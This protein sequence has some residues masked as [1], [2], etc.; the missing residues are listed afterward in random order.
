MCFPCT[1]LSHPV[2]PQFP[3]PPAESPEPP[4]EPQEPPAESPEPPAESPTEL[5]GKSPADITQSS[6]HE[7]GIAAYT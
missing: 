7:K 1:D 6:M 4:A 3:E 2:E 5:P